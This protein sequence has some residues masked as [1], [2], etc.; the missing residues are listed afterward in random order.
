MCIRDSIERISNQIDDTVILEVYNIN[1]ELQE[2]IRSDIKDGIIGDFKFTYDN[3]GS[4][5][6]TINLIKRP[7][8]DIVA[9][10]IIKIKFNARY[11][12]TGY[13]KEPVLVSENRNRYS[14]K[15][16]GLAFLLRNL[17]TTNIRIPF[18]LRGSN[19]RE[20]DVDINTGEQID[21]IFS[22][23]R[24]TH[25]TDIVTFL[26]HN[27]IVKNA[28]IGLREIEFNRYTLRTDYTVQNRSLEKLLQVLADLLDYKY[29]VDGGGDFYFS[30]KDR[31]LKKTFFEIHTPA[32]IKTVLNTDN[33]IN[34]VR[35]INPGPDAETS[36]DFI[37]RDDES[38]NTY[39][40]KNRVYDLGGLLGRED[41]QALAD[42][43]I[44]EFSQP[45]SFI[46]VKNIPIKEFKDL[47]VD[48]VYR[49]ILSNEL[50]TELLVKW[51]DYFPDDLSQNDSIF[52]PVLSSTRINDLI[53][54]INSGFWRFGQRPSVDNYERIAQ[55]YSRSTFSNVRIETLNRFNNLFSLRVDT[56][57]FGLR[58]T[59]RPYI[60]IPIP[61]LRNGITYNKNRENEDLEIE[62]TYSRVL[63]TDANFRNKLLKASWV[64]PIEKLHFNVLAN[65]RCFIDI[66]LLDM[67]R[68]ETGNIIDLKHTNIINY[69][70]FDTVRI[71]TL[72]RWVRV[73]LDL[74]SRRSAYNS[75]SNTTFNVMFFIIR[76]D[77]L[78]AQ[79]SGRVYLDNIS[80]DYYKQETIEERFYRASTQFKSTGIFQSLE[81]GR[82]TPK[83]ENYLKAVTDIAGDTLNG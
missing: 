24:G 75:L 34:Q 1:D 52:Q 81:L 33:L 3:K 82:E 46:T 51:T 83:I 44:R 38:V 5:S 21:S 57:N 25:V 37:G 29:G 58:N 27:V 12:Y 4:K 32:S 28:H 67:S 65:N 45:N 13:L 73:E 55:G 66:W 69:I 79:S 48:G 16:Q 59:T 15:L 76:H 60:L 20:A 31:A 50:T 14:F 47:L 23:L 70:V 10:S 17:T 40:V 72:N 43:I 71:G 63:R 49:Y 77:D 11:I 78:P 68:E 56:T 61:I 42:T 39:G 19:Y 2:V 26:Y 7:N 8:I 74:D 41:I 80:I 35:I 62:N 22:F 53:G 64:F 36:I 6:C 9:N 54:I 18:R 30:S